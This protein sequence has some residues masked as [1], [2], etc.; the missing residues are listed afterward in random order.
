MLGGGPV[1]LYNT[2]K[3][4][5]NR[6]MFDP[7]PINDASSSIFSPSLLRHCFILFPISK[8]KARSDTLSR[9][10]GQRPATSPAAE[11]AHDAEANVEQSQRVCDETP[12]A[13]HATDSAEHAAGA[14]C[15]PDDGGA[16]QEDADGCVHGE[17]D[18]DKAGGDERQQAVA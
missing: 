3:S 5:T 12:H 2:A 17:D 13:R 6:S 11:D 16:G 8:H 1:S 9:R 4:R 7:I 15:A 14:I 10:G 18:A